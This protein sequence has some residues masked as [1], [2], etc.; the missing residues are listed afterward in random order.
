MT[1]V[2]LKVEPLLCGWG[3]GG[4]FSR[5]GEK[6]EIEDVRCA[7]HLHGDRT[8]VMLPVAGRVSAA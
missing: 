4:H 5:Y 3:G 6:S 2:D 1:G 8:D 7:G